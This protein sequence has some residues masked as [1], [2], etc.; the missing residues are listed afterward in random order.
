MNPNLIGT[1]ILAAILGLAG[2]SMASLGL[3][4]RAGRDWLIDVTVTLNNT[5]PVEDR[6]FVAYAPESGRVGRFSNGVANMRLRRGETLRLAIDPAYPA[7]SFAGYD[8]RAARSVELVADCLS[9]ERQ[10]MITR[11]LREQFGN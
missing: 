4:D 9:S 6:Y 2:L 11:T 8:E 7:I 3:F 1:I 10:E 5:C